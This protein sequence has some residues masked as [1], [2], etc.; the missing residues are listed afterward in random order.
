MTGG[1]R[2]DRVTPM[3]EPPRTE[4]EKDL[5]REIV[6]LVGGSRSRRRE[7]DRP[8]TAPVEPTAE[9]LTP[10]PATDEEEAS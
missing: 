4:R 9:P 6:E 3:S 7:P 8:D 10:R 2:V 5:L 1:D